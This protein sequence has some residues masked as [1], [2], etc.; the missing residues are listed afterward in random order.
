MQTC[1]RCEQGTCNGIESKVERKIK[2]GECLSKCCI[3][4]RA[5][6]ERKDAPGSNIPILKQLDGNGGRKYRIDQRIDNIE[7]KNRSKGRRKYL[8]EIMEGN[9]ESGA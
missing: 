2:D 1:V 9:R 5:A 8:T 3:I 7:D 6:S 4:I